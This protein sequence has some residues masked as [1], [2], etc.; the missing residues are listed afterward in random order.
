MQRSPSASIQW[1]IGK[2]L[3]RIVRTAVEPL[4]RVYRQGEMLTIHLLQRF[5][6]YLFEEKREQ[7]TAN[8]HSSFLI[9]DGRAA[10]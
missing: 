6:H 8:N 3:G 9:A 10:A 1:E 2:A 5:L 7:T 4:Y